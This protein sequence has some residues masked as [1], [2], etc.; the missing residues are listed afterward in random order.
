[1]FLKNLVVLRSLTTLLFAVVFFCDFCDFVRLFNGNSEVAIF[2]TR[3]ARF[4]LWDTEKR[5]P[6]IFSLTTL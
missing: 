4:F 3:F 5:E 2:I 1:M 6:Y